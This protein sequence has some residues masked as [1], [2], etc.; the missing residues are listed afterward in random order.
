MRHAPTCHRV[1]AAGMGRPRCRPGSASL[2]QL[3][4][5]S[6]QLRLILVPQRLLLPLRMAGL[7]HQASLQGRP[8]LC[9]CQQP[10]LQHFHLLRR[11]QACDVRSDSSSCG[12]GKGRGAGCGG[13]A[14][15][16]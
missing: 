6:R 4:A 12:N 5:Q 1:I 9:L 13:G 3:A 11:P 2:L 16:I 10:R 7:L 15:S 8:R 14:R